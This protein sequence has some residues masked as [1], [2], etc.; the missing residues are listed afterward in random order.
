ML[1]EPV[2]RFSKTTTQSL[3]KHFWHFRF[4]QYH[5]KVITTRYTHTCLWP[6]NFRGKGRVWVFDDL[7]IMSKAFSLGPVVRLHGMHLLA[8]AVHLL[9]LRKFKVA[10]HHFYYFSNVHFAA[11]LIFFFFFFF[12]SGFEIISPMLCLINKLGYSIQGSLNPYC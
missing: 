2:F 8:L 6:Y 7:D 4:L 1:Q 3:L 11:A 9:Y 12:L 5:L 10:L